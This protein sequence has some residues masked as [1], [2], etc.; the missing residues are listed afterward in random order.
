MP[1]VTIPPDVSR[2]LEDAAGLT[3]S[4]EE[5]LRRHTTFR[6]GG[7]AERF[8]RVSGS[9]SLRELLR[10]AAEAGVQ[11]QLLGLGSNVLLPDDGLRGIVFVLEGEF[12]QVHVDGRRVHAG[13]GL[14]LA[15]LARQTAGVG[16]AGL[17]KLA[18]FPSSVGG[19]VFMNAG[20]YGVEIKDLIEEVVILTRHGV[21]QRLSVSELAPQY[22]RTSLRG[23]GSIVTR[24]T[25][26]LEPAA[27]HELLR[28]MRE[29]NRQRRQS[30]PSGFPN[31]G[32]IFRNPPG[33][34][35]GRLIEAA[36]LKGQ[37]AGDAEVSSVHANVIVNRGQARA[38]DVVDLMIRIREAVQQQ[39]GAVLEP[40]IVLVGELRCAWD[41]R[42]QAVGSPG[43]LC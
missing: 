34:F 15:N 6:I 38:A 29:I 24:V 3:V 1:T 18:G 20:C 5:P 40:E 27:P 19:A 37:R 8:V 21:E 10:R 7:P 11:T 28:T 30:M 25:L 4:V 13:A 32:S 35:A 16:L 39:F 26:R 22:R 14:P 23:T 33:D 17:E 9:A 2:W 42:A 43:T 31:V 41:V 36:G 12:L